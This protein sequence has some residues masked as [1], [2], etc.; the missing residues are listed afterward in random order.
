MA[1]ERGV[2]G[3]EGHR[4]VK[5][6]SERLLYRRW[7][8]IV[9]D[10]TPY[11]NF[12]DGRVWNGCMCLERWRSCGERRIQVITESIYTHHEDESEQKNSNL[13]IAPTC[14]LLPIH[15]R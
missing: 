12:E 11:L 9:T 6:L 10:C 14:Q 13:P 2:F 3:V 7:R 5:Y 8:R 15:S 1:Q 4:L